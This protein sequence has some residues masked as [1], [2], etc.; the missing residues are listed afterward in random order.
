MRSERL[1]RVQVPA[2]RSS[3]RGV[4]TKSRFRERLILWCGRSLFSYLT[5]ALWFESR[6]CF[7]PI[8]CSQS[9]HIN[10]PVRIA[11]LDQEYEE[12]PRFFRTQTRHVG[13]SDLD[14]Q[15]D[16]F[17][18]DM[19]PFT[20]ISAKT[21]RSIKSSMREFPRLRNLQGISDGFSVD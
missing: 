3:R 11:H 5:S 1:A 19:Q 12:T 16:Q 10:F 21:A 6:F 18:C 8:S 15:S 4:R 9:K 13:C 2:W 7:H 17:G 14:P 20:G